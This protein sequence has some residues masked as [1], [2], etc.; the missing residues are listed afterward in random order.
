[1]L[2]RIT[3]TTAT[4]APIALF[5][6]TGV[7]SALHLCRALCAGLADRLPVAVVG[8]AAPFAAE[9]WRWPRALGLPRQGSKYAPM[10]DYLMA[11]LQQRGALPRME[12]MLVRIGLNALDRLDLAPESCSGRQLR[13]PRFLATVFGER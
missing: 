7:A 13:L 3:P 11:G 8:K 6:E 5:A 12:G 10:V 2:E 4:T 9:L 1:G